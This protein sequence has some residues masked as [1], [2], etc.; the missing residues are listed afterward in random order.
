MKTF[1]QS[2]NNKIIVARKTDTKAI[3]GYAIYTIADP[4]DLRY[5]KKKRV[6][7]VYLLRIGVRLNCQRMGI[8]KKLMDFIL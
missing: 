5:G 8:G 4:I 3:V 1:W 2:A 7:Q 6:P